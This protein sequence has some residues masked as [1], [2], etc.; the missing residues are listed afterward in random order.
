[1]NKI[2]LACPYSHETEK[3]KAE[4][5]EAVTR[6]AGKLLLGECNVFSPITHSHLIEQ[7]TDGI[8]GEFDAWAIIDYEFIDWS[9]EVVVLCLPGWDRS[10]GVANEIRYALERGKP[11]RY[12]R[13]EDYGL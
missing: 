9:D 3:V 5:F 11:V 12:I 6:V 13:P 10:Y 4:R 8:G 2:Y 1:M 7:Y